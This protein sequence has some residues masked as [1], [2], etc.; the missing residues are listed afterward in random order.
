MALK[1]ILGN[2][3]YADDLQISIPD[4]RGG[5]VTASLGEVRGFGS[6]ERQALTA[7]AQQLEAAQNGLMQRVQELQGA[8]LLDANLNVVKQPTT[9]EI[10]AAVKAET[11]LDEN[12]AVFGSLFKQVKEQINAS[13]GGVAAEVAKLKEDLGK[14]SAITTQA[15]TGYLDDSYRNSFDKALSSLPEAVRKDVKLDSVIDYASKKRLTDATGRLDIGNAVDQMTWSA[16]KSYQ[17]QEIEANASK[18]AADREALAAAGR[19]GSSAKFNLTAEREG[20]K[21]TDDNG[22]VKSLDQ[23]IAEA[24][25]DSKIWDSALSA[26]GL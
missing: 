8:G 9:R 17:Q 7:R 25:K 22:R 10:K 13:F 2:S 6:S 21:P 20:F 12:D 15:M 5:S 23:V 14:V 3:A 16:L 11:G 24:S 18:L 4:G 26:A 19:P 1:D